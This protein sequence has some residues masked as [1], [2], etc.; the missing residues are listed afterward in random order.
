MGNQENNNDRNNKNKLNNGNDKMDRFLDYLNERPDQA[1]GSAEKQ[2]PP[3]AKASGLTPEMKERGWQA[4]L[5]KR[6][7]SRAGKAMNKSGPLFS[8]PLSNIRWY[9]L[10]AMA[11]VVVGA[12]LFAPTVVKQ[13]N[14]P[15]TGRVVALKG[16]VDPAVSGFYQRSEELN[17]G[18]TLVNNGGSYQLQIG[19][20]IILEVQGESEVAFTRGENGVTVEIANG[21]V[22]A[23]IDQKRVGEKIFFK[24]PAGEVVVTG[25]VFYLK[26]ID[27]SESYLCLCHGS[28]EIVSGEKQQRVSAGYHAGYRFT[29]KD[30]VG[31][32]GSD[33]M[34]YHQ[35][36][37][38]EELAEKINY[39]I[40]WDK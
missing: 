22:A 1:D 10:A 11:L 34:L 8:I 25:T 21:G 38:L 5:D 37:L 32:I 23:V 19:S 24:T 15:L 4:I 26:V 14:P 2:V 33:T 40:H 16:G 29:N 17:E 18:E 13:W 39:S 7:I 20:G 27:Q 35:D 30:G 36:P 3:F 9:A 31:Q 28:V 6:E 12:F